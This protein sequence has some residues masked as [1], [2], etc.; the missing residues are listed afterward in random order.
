[1]DIKICG[2]AGWSW[3]KLPSKKQRLSLLFSLGIYNDT[4]GGHS[5]GI[6]TSSRK[7]IIKDTGSFSSFLSSG[8]SS[9][10]LSNFG[11]LHTRYA[12]IGEK[13]KTNAHPYEIGNIIGAHNGVLSNHDELNAAHNRNFKVDSMHLIA[14]LNEGKTFNDVQGYGALEWYDKEK[15]CMY[16]SYFNNGS[17]SAVSIKGLG[18]VWSSD[19]GHLRQALD[20]AGI[21]YLGNNVKLLHLIPNDIYK[22]KDGN[23]KNTG[24]RIKLKRYNG[25]GWDGNTITS[26]SKRKK[27]KKKMSQSM[28]EFTPFEIDELLGPTQPMIQPRVTQIVDSYETIEANILTS[29]NPEDKYLKPE[30]G[31]GYFDEAENEIAWKDTK[32]FEELMDKDGKKVK[33]SFVYSDW[34]F[35][36]SIANLEHYKNTRLKEILAQ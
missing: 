11:F 2:L 24:K 14:H 36:L 29:E 13:N 9:W 34:E 7:L 1:M 12:S 19:L 22:I 25:I 31:S 3:K 10:A 18:I 8:I 27:K 28:S 30:S 6:F 26:S 32:N 15:D 17:L 16:I 20:N 21:P 23:I 5:Y 33:G 35:S 4:R